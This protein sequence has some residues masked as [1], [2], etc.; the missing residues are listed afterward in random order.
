[1][2]LVSVVLVCSV[3]IGSSPSGNVAARPLYFDGPDRFTAIT[4]DFIT[5]EWWLLSWKNSQVLCQVY[6]EH[7][8]W[9]DTSEVQYYC[10][11]SVTSQWQKTSPCV[12]SDTVTSA[13][14]CPG[15]YLH[16]AN[17]TPSSREVEV[18]LE[19]ADV[20]LSISEC[21]AI[22]PDNRC[23]TLPRLH[24]EGIEP[25]PNEMIISI[26]GF[27]D[28]VPF[29]CPGASCDLPLPPTGTN[30]IPVQFW[31]ESSYGDTSEV[32]S[33]QVRVIPWVILPHKKRLPR[34]LPHITWMY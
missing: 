31:A 9:P 17:V 19:S 4:V 28:G 23:S 11:A 13:S 8:G 24:L 32:F 27:M 18:L 14:Q 2:L 1:M 3:L 16:L 20:Q 7:E 15:L 34:I 26:Q 6:V 21:N 30:G 29:N 22:A 25:L 5:Y 12:F 10:G 33:A